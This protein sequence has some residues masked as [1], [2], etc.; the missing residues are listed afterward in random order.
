M[1]R[2]VLS[3]ALCRALACWGGTSS[4]ESG[5]GGL[6]AV[7]VQNTTLTI[8]ERVY[9]ES[10]THTPAMPATALPGAILGV[11]LDHLVPINNRQPKTTTNGPNRARPVL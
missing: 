7:R 6:G 8:G 5:E 11:N 10:D 9:K 1:S 3:T 2:R 4:G